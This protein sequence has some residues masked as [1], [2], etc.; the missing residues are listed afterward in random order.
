MKH[1]ILT[2]LIITSLMTG[3]LSVRAELNLKLPD[4]NVPD[5]GDPASSTLS[6][7]EETAL[8]LKF[9]R[10]LR[11]SKPIIEDPELSGWLRAL[12]NRLATQ[13]PGSGNFYFLI[14][15]DP[16][17]NAYAMPGGVIVIHSGL[18]LNTQ[19]ESEL[20]SVMAHEIAHVTQHHITRMMADKS[21]PLVTGLGVLAG[22][23]A[24]SKS[25]DAAQ[26][27]ITGTIATQLHKQ[28]V[29]S[30]Q[31]ES[32][33]DRVGLR[34]L[35]NAGFDPTAMPA[36]FEKLDRRTNDLYGDVTQYLHNHPLT[37]DRISDT[38]TRAN[39]LAKRS[40]HE[41][42][43]YLYAREK[44]RA[45]TQPSSPAVTQGNAQLA[46]YAQAVRQLRSGNAPATLKTLGTQ[47]QHLPTALLIAQAL[48]D[49][50]R[51][52][53]TEKLLTPLTNTYPG[54]DGILVL[55]AEALL[56]NKQAEQAWQLLSR[57]PLHEQ[58]SLEFLETR[59]RAAEQAG[60]TAE[61]YRTAAERSLRM[62]EYKHASAIL[63]Q[64]SRLPGTPA[65]T[66]ARLQAMAQDIKRTEKRTK[67]MD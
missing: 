48:N 61:A 26:A 7:T 52:A 38:R 44:L 21:N 56:A 54:Q 18:I 41:D 15:K 31:M 67:Q 45:L 51:Y 8:G 11:G 10:E 60:Q 58:T 30:Q 5:L 32:E 64:A 35:S 57:D 43:D 50:H 20:A 39:Q 14:L 59:Q 37:I 47:S 19:S 29:F 17:I 40:Y 6:N 53:E 55:L 1:A 3:S 49:T 27:I 62:G 63:E 2:S 23:A 13:A 22:A 28:R 24:A 25:P 9:V 4:M 16:S 36:F 46:Q 66:Q 33:A 42:S 12:G 65:P 34:I